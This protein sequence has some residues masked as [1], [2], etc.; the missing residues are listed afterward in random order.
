MK[1][2]VKYIQD[3]GSKYGIVFN[4]FNFTQG[5]ISTTATIVSNENGSKA[6]AKLVNFISQHR[7]DDT[8]LFDLEFIHN[9]SGNENM[10]VD[11]KFISK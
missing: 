5:V 7:K 1:N 3:L 2:H 4:G 10:L 8:R 9:V 6:F 11:V